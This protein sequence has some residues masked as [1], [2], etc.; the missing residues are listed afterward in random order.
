MRVFRTISRIPGMLYEWIAYLLR[1]CWQF[2][3]WII[4][5]CRHIFLW[6]VQPY[7]LTAAATIAIAFLTFQYVQYS[8]LQWNTMR[9]QLELSQRPWVEPTH[10]VISPLV[11]NNNRWTLVLSETLENHGQSVALNVGGWNE[12]FPFDFKHGFG[13]ANKRQKEWCDANRHPSPKSI[14]GYVLFPKKT[15]TYKTTVGIGEKDIFA[16]FGTEQPEALGMI[17]VGCVIYKSSYDSN[18]MPT[19]QTRYKYSLSISKKDA[20]IRIPLSRDPIAVYLVSL[21]ELTAD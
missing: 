17:I 15:I 9:Q 5:G 4:G 16:A 2:I 21:P 12:M 10:E 6:I 1:I 20:I 19:R 14:A 8:K 11:F 7:V 3:V 18:D 13:R